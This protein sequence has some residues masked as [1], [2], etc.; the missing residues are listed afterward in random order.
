MKMYAPS[1]TNCFAVARPMP[2]LAPVMSAIFPSSSVH[3]FLSFIKSVSDCEDDPAEGAA[4]NQVTERI[5]RFC[6]TV[7]LFAT[8]SF[9]GSLGAL[10]G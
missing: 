3:V 7:I 1:L 4:L 9:T 2:L 5:S 10:G 8:T 6:Q